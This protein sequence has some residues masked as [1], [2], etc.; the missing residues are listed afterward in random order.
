METDN[1]NFADSKHFTLVPVTSDSVSEQ[2]DQLVRLEVLR[3]V[4]TT[5][6]RPAILT[7]SL[8]WC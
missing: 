3:Q 8:I 7:V 2:A 6:L 5:A 4:G 1:S